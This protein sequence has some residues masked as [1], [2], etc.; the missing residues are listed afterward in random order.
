MQEVQ[1]EAL[2]ND[3]EIR[4]PKNALVEAN[5]SGLISESIVDI[6]PVHPI[7]KDEEQLAKP[8]NVE[9]CESEGLIVCNG[10][11]IQGVEGV[12][13]DELVK[14]CT[15]LA[16]AMD[17]EESL[18]K[19]MAVAKSVDDIVKEALP[20]VDKAQQMS[21]EIIPLLRDI[22]DGTLLESVESLATTASQAAQ[23]LHKLER[24]VMTDDNMLHIRES[25]YTLTETL[26][27][28]E[29]LTGDVS[30]ITGDPNTKHDIRN[31]IQSMS[32]LVSEW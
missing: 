22:S 21:E 27:N 24:T 19:F 25:I 14:Y 1:V 26:K 32:R 8:T 13:M 29:K 16:K 11:S 20:L 6:T 4:I 5:Q 28:V 12:S 3:N 18:E 10:G 23:D 7:P 17:S 30:S 9:D 31:L 15:K 2:I